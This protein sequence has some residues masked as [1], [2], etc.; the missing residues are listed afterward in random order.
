MKTTYLLFIYTIAFAL[1]TILTII[2]YNRYRL[3]K[4]NVVIGKNRYL[5]VKFIGEGSFGK[6]NL[7][8]S[9]KKPYVIKCID[10]TNA[11]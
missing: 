9:N 8:S 6:V 11:S 3:N 2:A 4:L 5:Y 1:A 10:L 7:Y